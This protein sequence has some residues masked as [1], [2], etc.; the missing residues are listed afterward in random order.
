MSPSI[1]TIFTDPSGS[2]AVMNVKV[3]FNSLAFIVAKPISAYISTSNVALTGRTRPRGGS[4]TV[5][6]AGTCISR[7]TLF[8]FACR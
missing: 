3:D 4:T 7:E 5:L 1:A 2:L 6:R 8:S